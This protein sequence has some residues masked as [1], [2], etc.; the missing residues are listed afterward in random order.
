[1][2]VIIVVTKGEINVNKEIRIFGYTTPNRPLLSNYTNLQPCRTGLEPM[3]TPMM[4]WN[5]G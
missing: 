1:M 5:I 3:R 4:T 2:K